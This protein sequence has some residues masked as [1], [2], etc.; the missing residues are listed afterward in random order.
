MV[1]AEDYCEGN[2]P[3]REKT[4]GQKT[5]ADGWLPFFVRQFFGNAIIEKT[6]ASPACREI[7]P[8]SLPRPLLTL[9]HYSSQYPVDSRL[10]TRTFGFEPVDHFDIH[11]QRDPPLAW[12]VPA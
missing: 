1:T 10:V 12:T 11:A 8:L 4:G 9:H 6:G 2:V 3:T 5:G 7:D